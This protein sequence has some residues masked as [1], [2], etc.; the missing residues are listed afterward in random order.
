MVGIYDHKYEYENSCAA[1]HGASLTG[2]GPSAQFLSSGAAPDLTALKENNLGIFPAEYVYEVIEGRGRNTTLIHGT[3]EMPMWGFRY[4]AQTNDP[5]G[6]EP[7]TPQERQEYV[8]TK[9]NALVDYI[10]SMQRE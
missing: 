7:M 6:G 4:M 5:Q 10:S 1:C 9:I 8:K 3:S 2:G